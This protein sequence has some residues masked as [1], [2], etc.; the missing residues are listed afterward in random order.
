MEKKNAI[1]TGIASYVPD[2]ILNNEELSRMV[3]TTDEWI[4]TRIG[5]KERR[6][7]KGEGTGSSDLGAPAVK[8]L[9]RKTNTTPEE[10][11]LM[12]CCTS[13][14]DY[15]FP[16]T[17]SIISE[18]C[19]IKKAYSFDI[20]AACS[21]FLFAMQTA[22]A[23]IQGGL[24]KKIIVVAAEKM[25]SMTDYTD[26]ST[27]PIFGDAASAVLVEPTTENL[28]VLDADL[29]TD[30]AGLTHLLMKAGGSVN[31]PSHE[32]VDRREHFIYQEG[33]IVFKYAVS[34][35]SEAASHIM[36]KNNLTFN[37]V[38]WFV[39][40]QANQRIIDAAAHRMGIDSSKVMVNIQKYGNTSSAS[41][42]LALSEWEPQLKK[43]DTIVMAAFGAG[44]TW[45]S[46]YLKWAYDT[47]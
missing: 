38:D 20:Q 3:D 45:G 19:G 41:I 9:L 22:A 6:I 12:I 30:G 16:S 35:M 26:R 1:I 11:D 15:R 36:E 39:P 27:C 43:G 10:I 2:Y 21:G 44:F 25:S 8:E 14:P 33:R 13:T 18:K 47:K 29:H 4:T 31:V 34:Y 28:G 37:D 24:A 23:Y 42:P 17:A 46:M 7:L 32:T 5:T 40:H